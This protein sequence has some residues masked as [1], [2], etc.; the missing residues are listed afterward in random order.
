MREINMSKKESNSFYKRHNLWD[1]AKKRLSIYKGVIQDGA[2]NS[3]NGIKDVCNKF[4]VSPVKAQ[5]MVEYEH[6]F[7]LHYIESSY[8]ICPYKYPSFSLT[9]KLFEEAMENYPELGICGWPSSSDCID[10]SKNNP[11]ITWDLLVN[12]T[13]SY[14]GKNTNNIHIPIIE[15]L[16]NTFRGYGNKIQK[17]KNKSYNM[18]KEDIKDYLNRTSNMKVDYLP[19]G[20]VVLSCILYGFKVEAHPYELNTF[21]R[22]ITYKQIFTVYEGNARK[23]LNGHTICNF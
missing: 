12:G 1:Y 8:N 10:R 15:H 17:T 7:G 21:V 3:Y 2:K 23:K 16:V 4:G 6:T 18:Y 5:E 13:D 9:K 11:I 22:E 14:P 19:Q 20:L